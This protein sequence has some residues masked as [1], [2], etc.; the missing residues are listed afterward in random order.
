MECSRVPQRLYFKPRFKLYDKIKI[1]RSKFCTLNQ[2]HSMHGLK[3][4]FQK[5]KRKIFFLFKNPD[6]GQPR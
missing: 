6:E 1:E 2:R 3:F 5:E 4:K